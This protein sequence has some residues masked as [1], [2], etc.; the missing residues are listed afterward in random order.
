MVD[1]ALAV[2]G[3]LIV[4][5]LL[6]VSAFFS[7]SE[8]ALFSL[9][10]AAV[11]RLSD[12]RDGRSKRLSAM[13]ADPH[14]LLVTILVGNNV[15]NVAIS[16]V[17]TLVFVEY[18]PPTQAAVATTAVASVV[19][20]VFGEIVPKAYGLGHAESWSLRVALP[21]RIV[22][23]AL[24]PLVAVFDAVTRVISRAIGGDEDVEEPYL[25]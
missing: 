10:S 23:R 4:L 9:D 20:L 13:L 12:E 25:N 8:T 3:G 11:G 17:T 18:L 5:V 6:A 16:T 21:L 7:S 22:E 24:W 15:V 19:V 1:L 14:R 2:G